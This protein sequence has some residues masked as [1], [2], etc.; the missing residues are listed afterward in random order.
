MSSGFLPPHLRHREKFSSW[1]ALYDL[2]GLS[3]SSAIVQITRFTLI[4]R[5][6]GLSFAVC[7][8]LILVACV[9]GA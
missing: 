5:G 1:P 4:M 3:Y 8:R 2:A 6:S 7:Y 9:M